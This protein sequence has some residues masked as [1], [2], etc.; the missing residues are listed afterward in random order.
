MDPSGTRELINRDVAFSMNLLVQRMSGAVLFIN[1]ISFGLY[2]MQE[3]WD[4]E[5]VK[6]R[7]GK[8]A[9]DQG[10][11]ATKCAGDIVCKDNSTEISALISVIKSPDDGQFAKLFPQLADVSSFLNVSAFDVLTNQV[12][13]P[14]F[15]SKNLVMIST[16]PITFA[17]N[18]LD[19]SA[20]VFPWIGALPAIPGGGNWWQDTLKR[21]FRLFPQLQSSYL[22]TFQQ[23][24]FFSNDTASPFYSRLLGHYNL[25]LSAMEL[26]DKSHAL[27][28]GYS[29]TVVKTSLTQAFLRTSIP[30]GS[31]ND[32]LTI[33]MA[34]LP[35][36]SRQAT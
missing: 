15:N 13:G 16:R 23:I 33:R 29:H 26:F 34:T 22:N 25:M 14:M 31:L 21:V 9:V 30:Y 5:L 20:G 10:V 11:I 19:L 12:D 27:D 1:N 4:S 7:L 18:D 17:R 36:S 8:H 32:F 28:Y 24:K 3:P 2:L 35:A 6:S